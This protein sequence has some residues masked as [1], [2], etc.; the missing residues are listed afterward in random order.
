MKRSRPHGIPQGCLSQQPGA[1]MRVLHI[2]NRNGRVINAV[3]NYCIN[4]YC[5]AVLRQDL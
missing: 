2:R 5:N 4:G 3:V 1:M